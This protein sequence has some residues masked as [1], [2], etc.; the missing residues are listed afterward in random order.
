[1]DLDDDDDDGDPLNDGFISCSGGRRTARERRS[2][3]TREAS[4]GV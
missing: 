4:T 2:G 1:M 3:G